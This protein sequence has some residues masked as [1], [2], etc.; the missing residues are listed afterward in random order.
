MSM[1]WQDIVLAVSIFAFNIA[2]IP[3]VIGKSKPEL[4]TSLL[5]TT[6]MVA[7]IVVYISL[8]L[9][10]TTVMS[11][12]NATLWGVLSVQKIKSKKSKRRK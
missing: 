7:T 8:S 10:Y 4:T 11:T 1:H 2:L 6:F 5:T 3:S 12:I 9:W